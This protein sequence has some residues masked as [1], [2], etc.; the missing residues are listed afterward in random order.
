MSRA[1][2]VG[3]ALAQEQD[4]RWASTIVASAMTHP[5][6]VCIAAA[7]AV[8]EGLAAAVQGEDPLEAARAVVWEDRTAESL[9]M[10]ERG[11]VPGGSAWSSH[12]RSHPLKT[13]RAAFWAARQRGG[14]E[15]VLLDLVHR[16]GDADTH[17]AIAGALLGARDGPGAIPDRWLGGLV[18]RGLIE[19][20]VRRCRSRDGVDLSP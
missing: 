5:A 2:A 3:I 14:F 16:G 12:G 18:V 15:E 20:L 7:L 19:F 17:G 13:L 4:L 6:P 8:A 11:W 1:A 10:V 9:E